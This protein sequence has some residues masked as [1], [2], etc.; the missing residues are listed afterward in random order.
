MYRYANYNA[1]AA[2]AE[3][4]AARSQLAIATGYSIAR[5]QTAPRRHARDRHEAEGRFAPIHAAAIAAFAYPGPEQL[6]A[7][8][9]S[10]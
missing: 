7:A 9:L 1:A 10:S 4:A 5:R 2:A 8:Y 6:A 3:R